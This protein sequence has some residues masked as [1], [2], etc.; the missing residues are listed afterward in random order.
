MCCKAWGEGCS[1]GGVGREFWWQYLRMVLVVILARVF[2]F[3]QVP[4]GYWRQG[5]MVA[6]PQ[7]G[8]DITHFIN[9]SYSL[10]P[11]AN[12]CYKI[13]YDIIYS[14]VPVSLASRD[15]LPMGRWWGGSRPY[16]GRRCRYKG[17]W[18]R[19]CGGLLFVVALG[20]VELA[21]RVLPVHLH[22]LPEQNEGVTGEW[23]LKKM[24]IWTDKRSPE[25][26]GVGVG[27]VAASH[28]AVVRFITASNAAI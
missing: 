18:R 27:F 21:H 20:A 2:N 25:R 8:L 13:T 12:G 14:Q 22:V 23:W 16:V 6:V 26:G 3:S 19:C 24:E 5:L 4:V 7:H 17:G 1:E 11:L 28:F 10:N 9:I 15:P